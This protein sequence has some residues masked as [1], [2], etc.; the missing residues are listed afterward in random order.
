MDGEGEGS[1]LKRKKK[2]RRWRPPCS[3]DLALVL[4]VEFRFVS[5]IQTINF[6][7]ENDVC[8]SNEI[9]PRVLMSGH[10]N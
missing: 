6:V 10:A 9:S 8:V 7:C 2:L 1:E 4:A 5:L 3:F